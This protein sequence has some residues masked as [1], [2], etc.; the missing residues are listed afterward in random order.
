MLDPLA[1]ALSG[2]AELR[3]RELPIV[4]A[5]AIFGGA[6]SALVID[7]AAPMIWMLAAV[8]V[9][10]LDAH[11]YGRLAEREDAL[12]ARE[13]KAL[14]V[15]AVAVST[16][17]VVL[18]VLLWLDGRAATAAAAMMLW[19]AALVRNLSQVSRR[20]QYAI[21]SAAPGVISLIVTPLWAAAASPQNDFLM[22]LMAV[23]CGATA[24]AY[25]ARF[26]IGAANMNA[27]LEDSVSEG[28]RQ[29]A[30]SRALFNQTAMSALLFD[31]EQRL[32]AANQRWLDYY[33][34]GPDAVGRPILDLLPWA[35]AHWLDAMRR[36][37]YGESIRFDE[38]E[39]ELP[40][41]GRRIFRWECAPVRDDF[42]AIIGGALHAQDV[43]QFVLARRASEE[44]AV[45]L[46]M[47]LHVARSTVWEI[48]LRSGA[49]TWQGDPTPIYGRKLTLADLDVATS[50]HILDEDRD[51][52]T[53]L[54][55]VHQRPDNTVFEH[56]F[57]RDDG[58]LVWVEA[59]VRNVRDERGRIVSVVILSKDVTEQKREEVA[60]VEAMARAEA[61]L[62]A[63]RA[64][65]DEVLGRDAGPLPEWRDSAAI[66]MG[67]MVARLGRIIEEIDIR[68][69]AIARV[70]ASMKAAR[71]SAESASVAKSQFLA[72]MSH[73]LRTPLNA[74]IGY[75]EILLE[76]AQDDGR[77]AE[78]KD[79][80][81]VLTAARQLLHLINE[82]LDLSKIEAGRMDV[83]P[84]EFDVRAFI[85]G[86]ADTVRPVVEKNGNTLVVECAEGL[87]A[88]FN[89][90]FKLSQCLLN[91]LS[92][93]GKFTHEGTVTLRAR[94]EGE[95]LVIDVADT[96]IGMSEEQV[97]RLFRPFMQADASTTRKYGGTGL[98]LAITRRMMQ[99]LGGDV[100]LE[101]APGKGSTFSLRAPFRF[102]GAA[103][104]SEAPRVA[105]APSAPAGRV[106]VV[107]DDEESARDL[108][109]RSLSRIGFEVRGAE[110]GADGVALVERALPALVLVDLQLPDMTGWA[111]IGALKDNPA[112]AD[113]PIVVHSVED[114][115]P[116][117]LAAGACDVLVKPADR[118]VMAAC[119]ARF[120]RAGANSSP[121]NGSERDAASA[122]NT[123]ETNFAKTA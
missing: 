44:N 76:E 47:A 63:K 74:I 72:N 39:V 99:L 49:I 100:T 21:A 34:F 120:A 15:W 65:I 9:F 62:D 17:Y 64:L 53:R 24:V 95:D 14:S 83:S 27:A 113:I 60:F 78:A 67:A 79:V 3:R 122:I 115:R 73:E 51:E 109:T 96:G 36:V 20:R 38:D 26:W 90:S 33:G 114:N 31:T 106:V 10:T 18:P 104:E 70:M 108:A 81:R 82:I 57:V 68:D 91:L 118:D 71:E 4:L 75:S 105:A 103:L 66:G 37:L 54:F 80:E 28:R 43:T 89:D 12:T 50:P 16:L 2:A 117:A 46:E 121:V 19:C 48:D 6:A 55:D 110:N 84:A 56:R 101:S 1:T 111:V 123:P 41:A 59:S 69:A 112:T 25:A 5:L 11:L 86:A 61:N 30:L 92:N 88:A 13:Q 94:R 116:R 35:P 87:G 29:L 23:L 97:A 22:S 85:E 98:G 45:R 77:D 42:G 32:L 40:R 93:A 102:A 7:S 119:V 107:I 8:V 52:L 58:A